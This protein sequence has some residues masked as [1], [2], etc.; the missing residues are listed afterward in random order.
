MR[1]MCAVGQSKLRA[2]ERSRARY[3]IQLELI[4]WEKQAV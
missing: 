1:A 4:P 3:H 2:F